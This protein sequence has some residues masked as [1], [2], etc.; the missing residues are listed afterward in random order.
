[1]GTDVS[2]VTTDRLC[3]AQDRETEGPGGQQ[4]PEPVVGQGEREREA[5]RPGFDFAPVVRLTGDVLCLLVSAKA[6]K[7]DE[8]Q[9][10]H[11]DGQ[12]EV[13]LEEA[14]PPEDSVDEHLVGDGVEVFTV[15]A[16]EVASTSE[17]PVED[18]ADRRADQAHDRR[19]VPAQVG[20]GDGRGGHDPTGVGQVV[21]VDPGRHEVECPIE[22]PERGC[23]DVVFYRQGHSLSSR[24][25]VRISA[26]F[27]V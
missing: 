13:H 27:F 3:G 22:D 4:Q 8:V 10:R 25:T 23:F 7:N 18:V 2:N 11:R 15:S 16:R 1:M 17:V 20:E 26:H 19:P 24:E 21:W 12:H 6:G 14:G 5:L 9:Y